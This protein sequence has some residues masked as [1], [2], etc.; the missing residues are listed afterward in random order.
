MKK[1]MKMLSLI[2]PSPCRDSD[3][4]PVEYKAGVPTTRPQFQCSIFVTFKTAVV[5]ALFS[6]DRYSEAKSLS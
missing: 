5:L 1:I 6:R 2:N 4:K 3:L